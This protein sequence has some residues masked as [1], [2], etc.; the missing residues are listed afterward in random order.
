MTWIPELTA[1]AREKNIL[2]YGWDEI[3]VLDNKAGRDFVFD[4]YKEM[5]LDG[6]KID[7][8]DSDSKY[9]MMFRDTACAEAAKRKMMVSFHGETL[10]RGHRRRYPNIM[11]NEGVRGAEYYTFKGAQSPD[12]RHNCTLPFTRNVVG[13]MDYTP[14]TFTIRDENP[15]TTT[16]AHE[17]ALA[18]AFESGWICMA[19]RPAAYLNSPARPLL[20]KIEAAWDQIHFIVGFPGEYFCVARCKA[21]K[22]FVA[23]INGGQ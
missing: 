16:Y 15:R 7:Y 13:S 23:G 21:G 17:L 18:F 11:T 10:P 20:E 3:K 14:V 5:G 1:Y 22:W 12:S 4:R 8:I 6:I 19:D 2:V 9:A